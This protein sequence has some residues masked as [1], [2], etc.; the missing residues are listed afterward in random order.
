M[1]LAGAEQWAEAQQASRAAVATLEALPP[2]R[3]LALAYRMRAVLHRFEHEN[4]EAIALAEKAIRLAEQFGD[5]RTLAMAYDT[6]GSTWMSL[7]FERGRAYAEQCLRIAREAGLE[8]RVAAV[9]AN[10]GSNACELYRLPDAARFLAEG[11]TYA[12]ERDLDLMRF[13][14]LAWQARTLLLLGRWKEAGERAGEVLQRPGGLANNRIPALDTVGLLRARRGEAG[15]E[16]ALDEALELAGQ[17]AHFQHLGQVRPA[18]AEA[19]WLAGDRARTLA[20]ARALYD[21]ALSKQHPWITGELAFWR[22]RAGDDVQPLPDWVA[23]PF[24]RQIA[25][26]WRAAAEAWGQLGC[27]YEQARALADG[28]AEA[29]AA[30]LARFDQLGAAPAAEALRRQMRAEGARIPRGPRAATR[31]NPFGLTAR[32][33]DILALLAQ[34]LT[35][36]EIAARL[37][38]SPKTVDHHV[39]AVLAKLDVRSR[40]EAARLARQHPHFGP[41]L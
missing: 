40:E 25:G 9:Y 34:D 5:T 38:L 30:A 13:F 15:A 7:D 12:S 21:L 17:A 33:V 14:M 31:E 28:D 27:P 41:G 29:Q 32:Q 26:D 6:L 10:L 37:H 39:S 8:A 11:I 19:A 20:E 3:E 2:G 16:A 24:D 22:W 4:A 36:A 18:R 23:P 35:N 1:L